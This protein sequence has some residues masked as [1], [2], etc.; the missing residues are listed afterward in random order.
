MSWSLGMGALGSRLGQ[1]RAREAG[2]EKSG[3]SGATLFRAS[4]HHARVSVGA[5]GGRDLGGGSRSGEAPP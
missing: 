1:E 5:Q 3:V 4:S 2:T